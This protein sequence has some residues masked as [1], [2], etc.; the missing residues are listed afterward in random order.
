MSNNAFWSDY[1][2][3][4]AAGAGAGAGA[5]SA[6]VS[7]NFLYATNTFTEMVLALAVLDLP[8]TASTAHKI[9]APL[10][11]PKFSFT[12]AT[13]VVLFHKE[14]RDA[15]V[16]ASSIA[17]AQR[18]FDPA[19]AFEDGEDDGTGN[20]ARVDKYVEEFLPLR[21]YGARVCL[22]NV[23]SSSQKVG[24]LMQIPE[25]AVPVAGNSRTGFRTRTAFETVE[26]FSTAVLEYFFYFPTVGK[27]AH[28]PVHVSKT[29]LDGMKV[30]G[31]GQ[32]GVCNV[33]AKVGRAREMAARGRARARSGWGGAEW[34]WVW[35]G[36][37]GRIAERACVVVSE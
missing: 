16:V 15:P 27:F 14:L 12:A 18:Y 23:S 5:G 25:G 2:A 1:A 7:S 11:Q 32:P 13:P 6:F 33:V 37:P 22:T 21:V 24:V 4:V 35:V 34:S 17:V 8:F 9:V 26:G 3:F 19:D 30:I 36:G 29:F 10:G 31:C 28:F 20:V